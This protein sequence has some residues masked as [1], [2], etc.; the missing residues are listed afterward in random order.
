VLDVGRFRIPRGTH[1]IFF[2]HH[3]T[4]LLVVLLVVIVGLLIARGR[5]S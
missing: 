3:A 1:L 5:Q 2:S 4:L